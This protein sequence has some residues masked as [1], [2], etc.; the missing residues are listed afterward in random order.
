LSVFQN[1]NIYIRSNWFLSRSGGCLVQE[2]C[3][4]GGVQNLEGRSIG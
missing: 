1:I 3:T 4:F 2:S